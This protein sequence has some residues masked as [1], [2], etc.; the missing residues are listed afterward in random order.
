MPHSRPHKV[1]Q[2]AHAHRQTQTVRR[3]VE[4]GEDHRPHVV[5]FPRLEV[6]RNHATP[7]GEEDADRPPGA[8]CAAHRDGTQTRV[9]RITPVVEQQS[10][11]RAAS[12]SSGLFAIHVVQCL[13]KEDADARQCG[14]PSRAIRR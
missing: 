5:L 4:E 10:Q 11:G 13:V 9:D 7:Q 12:D 8:E 3:A 6:E 1:R 2:K 14:Q